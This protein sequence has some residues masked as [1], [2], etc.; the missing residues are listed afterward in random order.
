[1]IRHP[2]LLGLLSVCL[3]SGCSDTLARKPPDEF[4]VTRRAPLEMPP[5]DMTALPVPSP[6]A[7]RPQERTV[8]DN[9]R[10]ALT[11]KK[12]SPLPVTQGEDAL[13]GRA[14]AERADPRIRRRVD[15]ESAQDR[16]SSA[17]VV[18]KLFGWAGT[19]NR[20]GGT[21]LD[22]EAE[23]SRLKQKGVTVVEKPAPALDTKER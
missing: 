15:S 16:D 8:E 14:G 18:K 23:A 6:G 10:H 21:A 9:V 13:A 2:L 22:P 1:M 17:P 3:A 20:E 5:P 7:P 11:G 19:R 12:A 4:A